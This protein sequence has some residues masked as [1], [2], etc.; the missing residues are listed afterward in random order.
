MYVFGQPCCS[1]FSH[2]LGRK[3]NVLPVSL[4]KFDPTKQVTR[5]SVNIQKNML[6]VHVT[7]SKTIQYRERELFIPVCAIQGNVLCPVQA[8][9]RMVQA[10][11]ASSI[12]PAFCYYV[13]SK[14][15]PLTSTVFVN[16][17]R[18]WLTTVGISHV[19]MYS[20]HSFRRGGATWAFKAGVPPSLIQLQGDWK[21]QCYLR[22][23]DTTLSQ[24]LITT[25]KMAQAIVSL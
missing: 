4:S 15:V 13:G 10:V 11:P 22:Y 19:N 20:A 23:I 8:Y 1:S 24:R 2:S 9:R 5:A 17:F 14:C 21:S 7:W 12:S 6:L 18:K 3:S 25:A 16:V